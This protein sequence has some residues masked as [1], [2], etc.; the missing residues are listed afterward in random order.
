MN[1]WPLL[2]IAVVVVGL[3]LRIHPVLVVT[4]AAL[5]TGAAARIE[6]VALLAMLG[7]G[8]L[9]NRYLL[10]FAL[11]LPVIGVLERRGLKEH[12]QR[13]IVGIKAATP[14]R[15]LLAYFVVRQA[16]ATLGLTSL[17]GHAQTVRPLLAPMTEAAA[18]SAHGPLPERSRQRLKAFAAGTDNIA[19][20][21]GEDL[22]LAFGAVLLISSFYRDS[23]LVLEPLQIALWGIPTA[24]AALAIH[25]VRILR[26]ERRLAAEASRA[27]DD[28]APRSTP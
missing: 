11:T 14:A 16:A 22:F 17:G 15:L 20:F 2:G 1:M 4:A 27:S 10:L 9:K 28:L 25:G 23:G 21:F 12:A 24:I 19:L 7:R 5:V 6:A 18:E 26:L 13:W 8:F 3:P